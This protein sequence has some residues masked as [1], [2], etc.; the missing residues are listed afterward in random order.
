MNTKLQIKE[1]II[2]EGKYDKQAVLRAVDAL[3]IETGGFSIFKNK[4]KRQEVKKLAESHGIIILTDSDSAGQLIRGHL[5]GIIPDKYIK[6]AYIP[7]IIGKERR[8]QTPS[9]EN[10]IGVEGLSP[11]VILETLQHCG[12]T[13]MNQSAEQKTN[14]PT[15]TMATLYELELNGT[16]NAAARR[17]QLQKQLGLPER[18]SNRDLLRALNNRCNLETLRKITAN[19]S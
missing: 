11:Q 9:K 19:L 1:T 7:D 8:K 18:M 2:V 4:Q 16:N 13:F 6:I 15:I 17:Q 14:Q 3:I 12:A 5:K 10:K